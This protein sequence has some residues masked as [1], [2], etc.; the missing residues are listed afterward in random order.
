M[1]TSTVEEEVPLP[2]ILSERYSPL[3]LDV[4]VKRVVVTTQRPAPMQNKQGGAS[5]P[6][7]RMQEKVDNA[8]H[9][10]QQERVY[11]LLLQTAASSMF[12][13]E[14]S[15]KDDDVVLSESHDSSVGGGADGENGD[16]DG[17]EACISPPATAPVK[18]NRFNP[19]DLG[20]MFAS[21]D[22][23][24]QHQQQRELPFS[25]TTTTPFYGSMGRSDRAEQP[26][27]MT[28]TMAAEFSG[29]YQLDVD[30]ML[31]HDLEA[32]VPTPS[33]VL[34][35]GAPS[36]TPGSVIDGTATFQTSPLP[37]PSG[38]SPLDFSPPFLAAA[39][40]RP[41]EPPQP[42]LLCARHDTSKVA[43]VDQDFAQAN[44]LLEEFKRFFSS[45]P[46]SGV[47]E[48]DA[49]VAPLADP[50]TELAAIMCAHR[51]LVER[52]IIS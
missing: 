40:V 45:L 52:Q 4:D 27:A 1:N 22:S 47:P 37:S 46:P 51:R 25:P 33:P 42:P 9:K 30:A 50:E 14:D 49:R 18:G 21:M 2:P 43:L 12:E 39:L 15:L 7:V 3:K 8:F 6:D 38:S 44:A 35:Q 31:R 23:P 19:G 26:D 11:D 20:A 28:M 10:V 29:G 32:Y 13:Q 16:D 41:P 17:G 24:E 5:K 48:A 36:S 34:S